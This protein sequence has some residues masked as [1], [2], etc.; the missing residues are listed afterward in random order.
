MAGVSLRYTVTT[1]TL[2]PALERLTAA[3]I[4]WSPATDAIASY[5]VSEVAIR[6]EEGRG[7]DGAAWK[8]SRRAAEEGGQTLV[9]TG[10]L[11]DSIVGASDAVSARV[12]TNVIYAA[13]HQLGGVIRAKGRAAGGADALS[14]GRGKAKVLR[15]SVTMPARPFLGFGPGDGDAIAGYLRDHLAGAWVGAG[16]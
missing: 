13:I 11:Q 16:A 1:D 9:D 14:F 10:R 2:G 8:P 7:P 12:G 5:L 3:V 4:D 6:F 15:T